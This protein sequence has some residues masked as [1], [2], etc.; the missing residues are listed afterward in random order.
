MNVPE[1]IPLKDVGEELANFQSPED[2]SRIVWPG[3]S[4]AWTFIH[5]LIG[6]DDVFSDTVKDLCNEEAGS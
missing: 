5:C 6:W 1:G 2:S 4:R 3:W